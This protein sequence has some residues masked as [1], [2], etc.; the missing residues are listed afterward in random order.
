MKPTKIT[1]R[2]LRQNQYD[3]QTL[4][5]NFG[6]LNS[7]LILNTQVLTADFCAEFIL[8]DEYASSV[9][10]TYYFTDCLVLSKQKHIT[11]EELMAALQKFND[12][13][14]E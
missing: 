7:R 12:A 11:E 6:E 1:N 13:K 4:E 8:N 5:Y 2:D 3:I 9:E 14:K 10:D